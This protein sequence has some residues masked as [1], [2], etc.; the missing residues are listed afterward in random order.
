MVNEDNFHRS[1]SVTPVHHPV[2]NGSCT[3]DDTHCLF[4]TFSVTENMYSQ[5]LNDF[6]QLSRFQ[7]AA[8]DQTVK[9]KSKQTLRKASGETDASFHDYDQVGS[10]CAEINN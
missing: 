7:C 2:I 8:W 9:L 1:K 6:T 4:Y 10:R 5:K 3:L